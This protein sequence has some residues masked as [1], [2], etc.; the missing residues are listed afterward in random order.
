MNPLTIAI[1]IVIV[2]T[3]IGLAGTI[4]LA[5]KFATAREQISQL[6]EVIAHQEVELEAWRINGGMLTYT[7][8]KHN[9]KVGTGVELREAIIQLGIKH[10]FTVPMVPSEPAYT[11]TFHELAAN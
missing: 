3:V 11:S 6:G 9:F 4:L 8:H 7:S 5:Y 1:T 10:R 2:C